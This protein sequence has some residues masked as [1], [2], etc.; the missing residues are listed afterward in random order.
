MR[1]GVEREGW[2]KRRGER[3]KGGAGLGRGGQGEKGGA[4]VEKDEGLGGEK[5][6]GGERRAGWERD[7]LTSQLHSGDKVTSI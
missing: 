4:R 5:G 7:C 3:R 2:G 1:R 6:E